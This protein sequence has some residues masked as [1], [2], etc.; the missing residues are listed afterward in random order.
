MKLK[1]VEYPDKRLREVSQKVDKFDSE[2]HELLDA[3]YPMM[4]ETNG[5]GLAAI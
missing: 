4:I 1:I 5:I 2:L 3:M